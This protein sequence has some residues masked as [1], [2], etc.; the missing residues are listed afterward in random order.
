LIML[1]VAGT[2]IGVVRGRAPSVG[3]CCLLTLVPAVLLAVLSTTNVVYQRYALYVL[4][5]FLIL[6]SNGAMGLASRAWRRQSVA[7][8]RASIAVQYATAALLVIPFLYGR[9]AQYAD[10]EHD[11]LMYQP[12]MRGVAAYLE[13]NATAED[14]ILFAGWDQS[15]AMFY[16]KD[17]PPAPVYNATDPRIFREQAGNRVFWAVSLEF[18]FPEKMQNDPSW[19]QVALLDQ[20][21]IY[22]QKPNPGDT[23]G[24]R[25]D[26]FVRGLNEA[27]DSDRS[28][29][30]ARD[31]FRGSLFQGRGDASTAARAYTEAGTFFPIGAEYLRSAQGYAARGDFEK[32][33]RDGLISKGLQPQNPE[34]HDWM[35]QMLDRQGLSDLS[36]IEADISKALS[37]HE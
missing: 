25:L 22:E 37:Q 12:D 23:L 4:P 32:A 9:A 3:L 21:R 14:S 8:G 16:W 35:A 31:V 29:Q 7:A 27:P 19:R 34:V 24:R 18:P 20:V 2:W 15:V 33:W 28:M 26:W 13:A 5:F 6:V 17:K 11:T 1:A 10:R 36:R 30:Q